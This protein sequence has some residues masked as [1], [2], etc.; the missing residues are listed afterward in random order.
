MKPTHS[1]RLENWL[2]LEQCEAL[3]RHFKD[4]YWPV[5]VNGVPGK[6]FIMPGG[7]FGGEIQAGAYSNKEES[8]KKVLRNIRNKILQDAKRNAATRS[9][10]DMIDAENRLPQAAGAFASVDAV[11]AAATSGKGQ[12]LPFQKSGIAVAAI[13][14]AADL[15]VRPGFPTAGG[16][17]SAAPGG[18]A[19]TATNLG[20]LPFKNIGVANSGHYLSWS[21]QASVLNNSL[22]LYDRIFDVAKTMNSTA[23]ENV[24]GVPTRYQNQTTG[25]LD[26]I[27]GNFLYPTNP[28]TVLAATAHNWN[29]QYTDDAGNTGNATATGTGLSACA[30]GAIDLSVANW[31]IPLAT[32]DTGIKNLT[33]MTCSAAVATGTIDFVIGHPIAVNA[34][35]IANIACF[36]DGLYTSINLATILDNAALSFIELPKPAT[37]ATNYSGLVRT[38]SE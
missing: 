25:A 2:G 4:F 3:S 5:P 36:D 7:D 31:F 30:V 18:R 35:P 14:N 6:V 19:P 33:Q 12:I 21:L 17:S 28:T 15:W 34:C 37:T 32:G 13:G 20:A 26:Y 9:L 11:V 24:T 29:C 27:G 1:Q 16:A 22:L 38:V 10:L 23:A 8:A